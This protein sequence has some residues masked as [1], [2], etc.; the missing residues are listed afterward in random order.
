MIEITAYAVV[1]DGIIKHLRLREEVAN[2]SANIEQQMYH[3]KDV[4]VIPVSVVEIVE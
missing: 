2:A 3:A 1:V 4:K